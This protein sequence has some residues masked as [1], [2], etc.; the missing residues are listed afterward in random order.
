MPLRLDIQHDDKENYRQKSLGL[1]RGAFA[2]F[3]VH[4]QGIAVAL[5]LF[6][7]SINPFEPVGLERKAGEERG[8]KSSLPRKTA[9]N[10][11]LE[12]PCHNVKALPMGL[13]PWGEPLFVP[14]YTFQA[15]VS[16]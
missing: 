6:L 2:F 12:R 3:R 15:V 1:Y 13:T 7:F 5:S 16:V 9:Q 10:L 11:I 8:G 4:F 14:N